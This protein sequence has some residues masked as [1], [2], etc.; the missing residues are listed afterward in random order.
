MVSLII[1]EA[2]EPF[3]SSI[4]NHFHMGAWQP[5][6]KEILL[7]DIVL[8]LKSVHTTIHIILIR[9]KNIIQIDIFQFQSLKI[10]I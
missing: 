2:I 7:R 6:N 5:S 9:I 8:D 3:F 1:R 4:P 10:S